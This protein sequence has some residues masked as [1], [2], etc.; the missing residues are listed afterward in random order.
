M[1]VY[2]LI[3]ALKALYDEI[4]ALYT[5]RSGVMPRTGLC[6]VGVKLKKYGSELLKLCKLCSLALAKMEAQQPALHARHPFNTQR[7][8]YDWLA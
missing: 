7:A 8:K 1:I 4:T 6:A 2:R 3:H 5:T